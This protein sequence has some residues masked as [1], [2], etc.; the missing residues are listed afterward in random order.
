MTKPPHHPANDQTL[1]EYLHDHDFECPGCAYNLR[2]LTQPICAECGRD[3]SDFDQHRAR[4]IR[5]DV[6]HENLLIA[7][8]AL[9]LIALGFGAALLTIPAILTG[10]PDAAMILVICIELSCVGAGLCRWRRR[11]S[12]QRRLL[13]KPEHKYDG[14]SWAGNCSM[15]IIAILSVPLLGLLMVVAGAV[16]P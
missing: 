9:C 14:V 15:F 3:L 2:G 8:S 7:L 10:K 6:D 4:K 16:L 12:T 5:H 1:I 13:N 11:R